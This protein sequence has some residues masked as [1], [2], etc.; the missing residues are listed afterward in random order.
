MLAPKVSIYW[1]PKAS[2]YWN[3]LVMNLSGLNQKKI[4]QHRSTRLLTSSKMKYPSSNPP[5]RNST[6]GRSRQYPNWR[7]QTRMQPGHMTTL[8]GWISMSSTTTFTR[9]NAKWLNR[10]PMIKIESASQQKYSH[11]DRK[12]ND[13]S[14]ELL[15]SQ[16][17]NGYHTKST[18]H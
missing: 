10:T 3:P 14:Q 2:T 1:N 7:R 13:S 11:Y 5:S 9:S 8:T 16:P 12:M 4:P 6:T 17:M 18:V 15:S